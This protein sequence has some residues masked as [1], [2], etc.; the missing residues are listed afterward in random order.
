M[1]IDKTLRALTGVEAYHNRGYDG[2]G[3]TVAVVDTGVYPHPDL[4]DSLL[5]G[6]AAGRLS[7]TDDPGAMAPWW[8]M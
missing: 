2:R 5:P 8:P 4:K 1:I 7:P 6:W 3:V